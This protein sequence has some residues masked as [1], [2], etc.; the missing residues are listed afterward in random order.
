[1]PVFKDSAFLYDSLGGFWK[2]LGERDDFKE[3][4]M[5]AGLVIKF[6]ITEP[7]AEIWIAPDGVYFGQQA[8][9][10]DITMSLTADSCHAFWMK[11]LSL[12][13]ALAKRKIKAKGNIAKILK[14]L[15]V[16]MP[17]FG[18]YPGYMEKFNLSS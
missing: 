2:F 14:L 3:A 15:P 9:K 12:P 1:M 16:I 11:E 10:A 6:E 7:N 5:K 17:A 13:V 4:A 18:L 8:F